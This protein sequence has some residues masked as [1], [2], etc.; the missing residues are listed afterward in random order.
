MCK[1]SLYDYQIARIFFAISFRTIIIV[2]T[3]YFVN[4]DYMYMHDYEIGEI[5]IKK[6]IYEPSQYTFCLNYL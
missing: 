3:D 1:S 6:L 2:V 5:V 4:K